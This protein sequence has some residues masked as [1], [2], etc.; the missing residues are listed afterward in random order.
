MRQYPD[1]G[2][3]EGD[4]SLSPHTFW[5]SLGTGLGMAI[6]IAIQKMDEQDSHADD[7]F[8]LHGRQPGLLRI[9]KGSGDVTMITATEG[10][11]DLGVYSRAA[12]KIKKYGAKGEYPPI[13][14]W[15]S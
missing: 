8:A 6:D 7:A 13:T 5:A 11:A 10:D 9:T 15:A 2:G 4:R 14:C 1:Q 12:D 3:G